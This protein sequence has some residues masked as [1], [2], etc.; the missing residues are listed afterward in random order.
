MS[1][2]IVLL[3]DVFLSFF[4]APKHAPG[5]ATPLDKAEPSA[6]SLSYAAA[7]EK[8]CLEPCWE[9]SRHRTLPE[10]ADSRRNGFVPW[11]Q[12]GGPAFVP[13]PRELFLS[14]AFK[15]HYQ[16][17]LMR[18]LY[19]LGCPGL[20]ETARLLQAPLFKWG[21]CE[22]DELLKRL[23]ELGLDNY[24]AG[25]L[26]GGKLV[27][28]KRW[29]KWGAMFL[30]PILGPAPG[31]PVTVMNRSLLVCLPNSMSWQAFDEAYDAEMRHAAIDQWIDTEDGRQ[32]CAKR[33]VNP[34]TFKRFTKYGYDLTPRISAAKELA[35]FRLDRDVDR[36]IEIAEKIILRH[37]GLV[38]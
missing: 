38:P 16:P 36:L 18:T 4:R 11:A 6:L 1:N 33:G 7:K 29:N 26:L 25:R 19:I 17:G 27:F 2:F 32:L 3:L 37:L 34:D 22:G 24:A 35:L 14:N 9:D 31:S 30:K 13:A 20:K 8:P 15:A 5:F 12:V 21:T 28:E 23:K 10:S